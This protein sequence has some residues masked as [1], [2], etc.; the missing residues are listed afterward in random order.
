MLKRKLLLALL[1]PVFVLALTLGA[2]AW[3][4]DD[5]VDIQ[6]EVYQKTQVI[7]IPGAEK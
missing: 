1:L 6:G 4:E 2:I 5:Y 7:Q 3:T